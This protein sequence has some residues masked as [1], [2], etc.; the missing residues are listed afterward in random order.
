[1]NAFKYFEMGYSSSIAYF[2]GVLILGLS[3]LNMRLN[4]TDEQKDIAKLDKERRKAEKAKKRLEAS[5]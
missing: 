2:M 4:R 5:L 1:M 3:L